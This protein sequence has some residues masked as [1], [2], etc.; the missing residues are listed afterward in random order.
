MYDRLN[1]HECQNYEFDDP[2]LQNNCIHYRFC[3]KNPEKTNRRIEEE[4]ENEMGNK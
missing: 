2:T 4:K 1:C 3:I